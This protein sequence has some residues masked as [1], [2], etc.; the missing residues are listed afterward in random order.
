MKRVL[1]IFISVLAV[2]SLTLMMSL[3]AFAANTTVSE[4]PYSATGLSSGGNDAYIYQLDTEKQYVVTQSGGRFGF[5]GGEFIC[6]TSAIREFSAKLTYDS[7]NSVWICELLTDAYVRTNNV[8]NLQ[9]VGYTF[10]GSSARSTVSYAQLSPVDISVSEYSEPNAL[11]EAISVFSDIS[12]VS[13][14]VGNRIMVFLSQNPVT[15][16]GIASFVLFLIVEFITKFF[17]T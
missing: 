1:L 2:A 9:N 14:S 17:K 12:D 11:T 10:S 7:E 3:S 5:D 15:L 4:F 16:L 8:E 6:A 13:I